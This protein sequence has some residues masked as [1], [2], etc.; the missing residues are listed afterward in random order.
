M[1]F[2][3]VLKLRH[4]CRNYSDKE[5]DPE[6][7]EEIFEAGRTAPSAQNRQPWR[8]IVISDRALIKKVAFHSIVGASNFFIKNAHIVI[9]ACAD[10]RSSLKFNGQEYYLVDVAIAFQQ[11]MLAAWNR[12]VGSCWLAAF[13]EG[14]LKKLLDL[15]E[16]FRIVGL[17]P[18]GYPEDKNLY[19]KII[20]FVAKSG[21]R[22]ER[23]EVI[24][25]IN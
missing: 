9:V 2:M 24:L 11:M 25:M 13:D 4:S 10:T 8:F 7:L 23:S 16:H 17:S 3:D 15:P 19:S 21:K 12:G 18:F 20:S 1:E 6:I 5:I 14:L 22:K